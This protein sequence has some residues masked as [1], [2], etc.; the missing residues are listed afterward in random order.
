MIPDQLWH[1]QWILV[2]RARNKSTVKIRDPAGIQTQD[3][4]N[5]S[6]T[7]LPLSHS[8]PCLEASA[9]FQLILTLSEPDW[10]KEPSRL[11]G[12]TFAISKLHCTHSVC[13]LQ[14]CAIHITNYFNKQQTWRWRHGREAFKCLITL[15]CPMQIPLLSVSKGISLAISGTKKLYMPAWTFIQD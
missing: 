8:D 4:M 1:W 10:T 7:L 11:C 14:N 2:E 6:Q 5:T 9:E 13:H 15:K 12:M 3:L